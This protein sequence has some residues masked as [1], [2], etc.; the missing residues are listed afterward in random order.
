MDLEPVCSEETVYLVGLGKTGT[1]K[2]CSQ[3]AARS[4]CGA[5]EMAVSEG[6]L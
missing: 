3:N 2:H 1:D 5:E 6:A 4:L